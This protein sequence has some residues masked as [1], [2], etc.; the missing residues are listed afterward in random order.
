[1]ARP[2]G[3]LNAPPDKEGPASRHENHSS[4]HALHLCEVRSDREIMAECEEDADVKD[5]AKLDGAKRGYDR[6]EGLP[7][8]FCQKRCDIRADF[9]FVHV[10]TSGCTGSSLSRSSLSLSCSPALRPHSRPPERQAAPEERTGDGASP[11]QGMNRCWS[12][13]E[14]RRR[15]GVSG[16]ARSARDSALAQA[17]SACSASRKSYRRD[18]ISACGQ[19]GWRVTGGAPDDSDG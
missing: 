3:E 7:L 1:V 13:W 18:A 5:D 9:K 17:A 10:E 19:F 8:E 4:L 16:G 15:W 12:R 2:G 14:Q 6:P 11:G